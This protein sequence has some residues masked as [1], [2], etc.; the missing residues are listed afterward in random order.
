MAG[1]K[2]KKSCLKVPVPPGLHQGWLCLKV[3]RVIE[4]RLADSFFWFLG[5]PGGNS[6]ASCMGFFR[7]KMSLW[8]SWM[9]KWDKEASWGDLSQPL[10]GGWTELGWWEWDSWGG[11]P[12]LA[13]AGRKG[14]RDGLQQGASNENGERLTFRMT[15]AL[16]FAGRK[17][18]GT[19]MRIHVC[20]VMVH[21]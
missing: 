18:K 8:N 6:Q 20:Y 11:S 14:R 2:R 16:R 12:P 9:G 17:V 3:L 15:S 10:V 13:N 5:E 1:K 21:S 19:R 4:Q 7:D